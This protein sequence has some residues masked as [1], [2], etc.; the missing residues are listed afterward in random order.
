MCSDYR[1][2][3]VQPSCLIDRWIQQDA[4]APVCCCFLPVLIMVDVKHGQ[5]SPL[6]RQ[7]FL[8]RNHAFPTRITRDSVFE[9][10]CFESTEQR[11]LKNTRTYD[12]TRLLKYDGVEEPFYDNSSVARSIT[13]HGIGNRSNHAQFSSTSR[14]HYMSSSQ[15]DIER[16]TLPFS[17][18]HHESLSSHHHHAVVSKVDLA[19][20][21][22]PP[23][24]H[25]IKSNQWPATS[26]PASVLTSCF[27][28][29]PAAVASSV[30]NFSEINF[31]SPEAAAAAAS[32]RLAY[33]SH[34]ASLPPV[35]QGTKAQTRPLTVPE[36]SPR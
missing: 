19:K 35:I 2:N 13:S 22:V 34:S 17:P 16:S 21:F 32:A 11:R 24:N 6:R 27:T 36:S 30:V 33:I 10:P 18:Q 26:Q 23:E 20:H 15:C 14:R 1:A 8:Q 12:L 4:D 7:T 31:S 29:P 5:G 9:S 25:R 3:V 28:K